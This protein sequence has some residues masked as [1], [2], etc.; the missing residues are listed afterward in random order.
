MNWLQGGPFYELSF[1]I[2]NSRNKVKLINDLVLLFNKID[3]IE[4]VE[5]EKIIKSKIESYIQKHETIGLIRRVFDT[6]TKI[7]VAGMRKSRLH[8]QELSEELVKINFWFYGST[9]DAD[10]WNQVGLKL[11]DKPKFKLLFNVLKIKINPIL[12]TIAYEEDC[13]GLFNTSQSPKS[14]DYSLNKLK[15]N[16]MKE[17]VRLNGFEY[18]WINSEQ[19]GNE[20]EITIYNFT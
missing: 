5:P 11:K 18:C 7:N 8:I 16:E 17:L 2:K 9:F 13:S 1:L 10:E 6:N 12:G 4:F 3:V 19:F 15:L 14:S 20:K